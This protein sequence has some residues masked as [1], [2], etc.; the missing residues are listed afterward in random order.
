MVAYHA[1]KTLENIIDRERNTL[2][3]LFFCM[4]MS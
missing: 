1:K 2:E 3:M 4:G